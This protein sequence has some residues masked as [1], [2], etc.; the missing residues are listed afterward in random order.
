MLQI[1]VIFDNFA[2]FPGCFAEFLPKMPSIAS[3]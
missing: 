3:G 1:A 2:L